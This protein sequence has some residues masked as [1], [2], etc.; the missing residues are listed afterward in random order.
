MTDQ[1]IDY[2]GELRRFAIFQGLQPEQ[3]RAIPVSKPPPVR[4]GLTLFKQGEFIQRL[5]FVLEG[6]VEL[7]RTNERGQP[8]LRR[9]VGP[10]QVLGR[11][12]MDVPEGQLGT[13]RTLSTTQLLYIDR[14]VLQRLRNTVPVL[15]NQLDRSEVIGHL[16][17]TPYFATLTDD[18]VRW[19]SDIVN[20]YDPEPGAVIFRRGDG[21]DSAYIIRQGRVRLE[22]GDTGKPAWLSAGAVFGARSVVENRFRQ[23]NAIAETRCHLFVLP[24]EDLRAVIQNYP[25]SAWT[26]EPTA[27]ARALANVPLFSQLK[28][29]DLLQ[30]AG[31]AMQLHFRQSHRIIVR[32]GQKDNY[33]YLLVRGRVMALT[34]DKNGVPGSPQYVAP[35]EAFGDASLLLGEAAAATVETL[36]PTDWIRIH[37]QDFALFLKDNPALFDRLTMT[38]ELRQRYLDSL[39]RHS[40]QLEGESMLLQTRRHWVVLA[41]NLS[42]IAIIFV[43]LLALDW[44]VDRVIGS[45]PLWLQA[46]FVLAIPLPVALWLI[47]DYLNDYYI[48]TSRRVARRDKVILVSEKLNSAPLDKVQEVRTDRGFI[49]QVF[50]YGHLV[51]ATAG[52]WGEIRFE[53]APHPD[54]FVSLI[55]AESTRA[56]IAAVP[57]NQESIRRQLQDRLHLGLEERVDRR[58]LIDDMTPASAATSRP[59]RFLLRALRG[60]EYEADD[61]LVW[62]KHWLGLVYRLTPPV[63]I[64]LL[65]AVLVALGLGYAFSGNATYNPLAYALVIAMLVLL[66]GSAFWVWWVWTDWTNDLYIVTDQFIEHIEKRPLFLD[67]RTEVT[68]Y[69]RVQNVTFAKPN[70]LAYIFN[71]GH[72]V[73]QT[74]AENGAIVF[75][76]APQPETIQNQI[77]RRLEHYAEA[78]AALR[79]KESQSDMADWFEAYATLT[80]EDYRSVATQ[81]G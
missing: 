3:L 76:F 66:G 42:S 48:V 2:S 34:V 5:Y 74:A 25:Q 45:P 60:L 17:A 78:Q 26:T 14:S 11:L 79:R 22:R 62:R 24:A 69:E 44:I 40:W 47:T 18:E 35:G 1:Q 29:E 30:L 43:L 23:S 32:Q 33:L 9:V 31:D 15:A 65:L 7:V 70:P 50:G 16:R 55:R 57:E 10:G 71:F 27:T 39:P 6:E 53:F 8:V 37:R 49:A 58:A 36:S 77:L 21:A 59:H 54:K 73:I 13:A 12:E 28:R 63:L 61:R 67:E 20:T 64:T 4:P 81:R 51:T 56:K 41:R 72:V 19:L 38:P 46:L 75:R 80:S 52:T 68:S